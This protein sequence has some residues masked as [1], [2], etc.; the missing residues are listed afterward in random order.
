MKNVLHFLLLFSLCHGHSLADQRGEGEA[1]NGSGAAEKNIII[2]YRDLKSILAKALVVKDVFSEI[3]LEVMSWIPPASPVLSPKLQPLRCPACGA[4]V[5]Q[6]AASCT[7]C[8]YYTLP[9]LSQ[10]P[11]I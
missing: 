2:A 5:A 11:M 7:R 6:L 1:G 9:G 3:E 4:F 8:A 10:E